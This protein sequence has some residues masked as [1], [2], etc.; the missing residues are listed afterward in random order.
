MYTMPGIK[1]PNYIAKELDNTTRK[2][3]W[4]SNLNSDRNLSIITL[5]A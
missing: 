5:I 4:A 3:F 1:N 2:F